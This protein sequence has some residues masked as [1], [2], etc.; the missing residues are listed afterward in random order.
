MRDL[1]RKLL[2]KVISV[3]STEIMDAVVEAIETQVVGQKLPVLEIVELLNSAVERFEVEFQSKDSRNLSLNYDEVAANIAGGATTDNGWI[4]VYYDPVVGFEDTFEDESI[5][6]QFY[7]AVRN[8][9]EHELVHRE[10][11]KR[12]GNKAKGENPHDTVKYLSNPS[13]MM[14][15][16]RQSVNQFL[17]LGYTKEQVAQLLRAPWD[18]NSINTPNRSESDVF[19]NY[20]EWFDG[21]DPAFKKFA[22]YMAQYL[23]EN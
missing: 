2:E 16:A 14:A 9:I 20:T 21:K 22:S 15:M 5:T 18:L 6:R 17:D 7:T 12:S 13:E 10:E 8:V 23:A 1:T 4:I 19:W 3:D 11:Q